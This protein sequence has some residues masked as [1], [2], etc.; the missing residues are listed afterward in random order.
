MVASSENPDHCLLRHFFWLAMMRGREFLFFLKGETLRDSGEV[1]LNVL[2]K[3]ERR[4]FYSMFFS[5]SVLCSPLDFWKFVTFV[6]FLFRKWQFPEIFYSTSSLDLSLRGCFSFQ[7]QLAAWPFFFFFCKFF[8]VNSFLCELSV[9][10]AVFY[11]GANS[12][13]LKKTYSED[14]LK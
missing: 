4:Q 13:L 11:T 9:L 5:T 3:E 2:S 1:T 10:Q 12:H 6:I 14:K 8:W 7:C